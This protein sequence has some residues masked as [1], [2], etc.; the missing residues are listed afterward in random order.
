[1]LWR[2]KREFNLKCININ[3]TLLWCVFSVWVMF[4]LM[5]CTPAFHS[6]L[7]SCLPLTIVCH[8]CFIFAHTT[9]IL[10]LSHCIALLN[11][12][13]FASISPLYSP[14]LSTLHQ[15][16]LSSLPY[17]FPPLTSVLLLTFYSLFCL[18]PLPLSL[19]HFTSIGQHYFTPVCHACFTRLSPLPHSL[20]DIPVLHLTP[21]SLSPSCGIPP[22]ASFTAWCSWSQPPLHYDA[23][24][25]HFIIFLILDGV[26]EWGLCPSRLAIV[27]LLCL[28][29]RSLQFVTLTWDW[30]TLLMTV[31]LPLY[32]VS[33]AFIIFSLVLIG[34]FFPFTHHLSLLS[35]Y[36]TVDCIKQYV[37][38]LLYNYN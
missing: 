33:R 17:L 25:P 18:P 38:A 13:Y 12:L 8:P 24:P 7:L 16:R 3:H 20:P 34:F 32:G 1:M 22:P 29:S 19:Q 35:W 21:L 4:V 28:I 23:L 30:F 14:F 6:L 9:A 11:I 31:H 37:S 26:M 15:H 10:Y 27:G 36:I 5:N 2:T